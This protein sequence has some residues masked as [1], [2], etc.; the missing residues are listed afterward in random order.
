[1]SV[2]LASILLFVGGAI[3]LLSGRTLVGDESP[4]GAI[5]ARRILLLGQKVARMRFTWN[6]GSTAGAWRYALASQDG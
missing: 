6:A 5:R 1:M 2:R 3:S 4:S